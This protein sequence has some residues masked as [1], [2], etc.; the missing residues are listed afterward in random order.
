MTAEV[1]SPNDALDRAVQM[2]L[3]IA[4]DLE[5]A[6]EDLFEGGDIEFSQGIQA[7]SVGL[8]VKLKKRYPELVALSMS[9][10]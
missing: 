8:I 4:H 5:F 10:T 3:Q 2:L 6:A 9:P 7:L 1:I